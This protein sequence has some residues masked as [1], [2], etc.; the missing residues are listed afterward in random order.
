MLL[1]FRKM[2]TSK[3]LW[4]IVAIFIV[5]QLC[6]ESFRLHTILENSTKSGGFALEILPM[7]SNTGGSVTTLNGII[8]N[9]STDPGTVESLDN[10]LD[11]DPTI[12]PSLKDTLAF[13][14]LLQCN[15]K[16][17]RYTNHI[18][19]P[20]ILYNISMST[21]S[22]LSNRTFWNPTIIALPPWARNQYLIVSMI[23]LE[24]A[25]YRQ[26]VMCEANICHRDLPESA[27][28]RHHHC[29][30]DDEK[31]LGINGGLR[32]ATEPTAIVVPATTAE[33]CIGKYKGKLPL[34]C[35]NYGRIGHFDSKCTYP[36]QDDSD[37]RETSK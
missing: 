14:S 26:S 17:N 36:K 8:V 35:F 11:I 22:T 9:A 6:R 21:Y 29:S 13:K 3:T 27:H 4:L 12:I 34:K 31:N 20:N 2:D 19:L 1:S 25:T 5:F 28:S 18:R 15:Y 30:S 37:E 16:P 10:H 32:C 24:N 23:Y 7:K 33:K